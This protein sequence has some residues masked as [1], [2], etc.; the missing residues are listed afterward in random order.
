MSYRDVLA[1]CVLEQCEGRANAA[2]LVGKRL[3]AL[4]R[5]QKKKKPQG[6]SE[7]PKLTSEL[8]P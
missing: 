2:Q 4:Q 1:S 7:G 6:S 8:R 5:D 3:A